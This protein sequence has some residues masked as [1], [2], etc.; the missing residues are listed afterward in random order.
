MN[1]RH[2]ILFGSMRSFWVHSIII[3]KV[4]LAHLILPRK[5]RLFKDWLC[6]II[7]AVHCAL[8]NPVPEASISTTTMFCTGVSM[9]RLPRRKK[10]KRNLTGHKKLCTMSAHIRIRPKLPCFLVFERPFEITSNTP[11]VISYSVTIFKSLCLCVKICC[12]FYTLSIEICL[13]RKFGTP[14]RFQECDLLS[15]QVS[16]WKNEFWRSNFFPQRV[17]DNRG[18]NKYISVM[19]H[20]KRRMWR[21]LTRKHTH[22]QTLDRGGWPAP[23][24]P[25]TQLML[26]L[27]TKGAPRQSATERYDYFFQ[28]TDSFAAY[29]PGGS[30]SRKKEIIIFGGEPL[31]FSC[32]C[33]RRNRN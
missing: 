32:P 2:C 30:A 8:A 29:L 3:C 13:E 16:S 5:F 14:A 25:D 23:S 12:N 31:Y 20:S 28:F 19:G 6:V 11:T 7:S 17:R 4:D 26:E 1:V 27:L 18:S 33:F 22:R 15:Q 10:G 9:P 21:P 24:P